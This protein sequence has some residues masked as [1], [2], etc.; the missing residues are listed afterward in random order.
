MLAMDHAK[1]ELQ[2]AETGLKEFSRCMS[3]KNFEN[4]HPSDRAKVNAEYT[5][6]RH[7]VDVLRAFILRYSTPNSVL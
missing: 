2:T 5:A 1:T 3:H 4:L 7:Y 6:F